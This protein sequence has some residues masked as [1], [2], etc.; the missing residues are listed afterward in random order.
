MQRDTKVR[1]VTIISSMLAWEIL[2]LRDSM[3]RVIR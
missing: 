3:T 2:E 1:K